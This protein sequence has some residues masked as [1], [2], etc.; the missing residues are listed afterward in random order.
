MGYHNVWTIAHWTPT[1]CTVRSML[2]FFFVQTHCMQTVH[3][4]IVLPY[5]H[6]SIIPEEKKY[7][8][9]PCL[10]IHVPSIN[11]A[12]HHQIRRLES[13]EVGYSNIKTYGDIPPFWVGFLQEIPRHGYHFSLKNP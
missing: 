6:F 3:L 12:I 11:L 10:K 1:S 7:N 13:S 5:K 9:C 4:I 8:S 2:L